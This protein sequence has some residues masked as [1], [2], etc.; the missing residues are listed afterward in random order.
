M[1]RKLAVV[2]AMAMGLAAS[3]YITERQWMVES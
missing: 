3:R 1:I 2:G